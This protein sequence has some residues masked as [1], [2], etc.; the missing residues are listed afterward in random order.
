[1]SAEMKLY[2]VRV[3]IRYAIFFFF[4]SFLW[5]QNSLYYSVSFGLASV[6][7]IFCE[8][9]DLKLSFKIVRRKNAKII[10]ISICYLHLHFLCI[11][12]DKFCSACLYLSKVLLY[13]YWFP[14]HKKKPSCQSM[15][16][17]RINNFLYTLASLFILWLYDTSFGIISE[18]EFC[19]WVKW[20]SMDLDLA[21]GF[22]GGFRTDHAW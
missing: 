16:Q 3:P 9:S 5:N 11:T 10:L 1:M 18:C 13:L 6:E 15:Q 19:G 20:S 7:W 2:F 22:S 8:S 21:F 4:F 12:W 17:A 14:Y